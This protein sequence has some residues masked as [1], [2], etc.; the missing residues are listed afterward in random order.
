MFARKNM[1]VFIEWYGVA[2]G[3]MSAICKS[4]LISVALRDVGKAWTLALLPAS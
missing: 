3:V 4:Q 2:S 1:Y